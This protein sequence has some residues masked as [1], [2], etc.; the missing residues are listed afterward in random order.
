MQNK[1]LLRLSLLLLA[2]VALLS[3]SACDNGGTAD[4]G[5]ETESETETEAATVNDCK[6][7]GFKWTTAVAATCTEKGMIQKVCRACETVLDTAETPTVAHKE[8]V[9][10][11]TAASCTATGLSDGKKC[12]SCDAVLVEQTVI[13]KKAHTE[14]V[15]PG[16]FATCTATGLTQGKK[17]TLCKTVTVAQTEIPALSHVEGDW[18]V[19]AAAGVGTAGSKHTECILCGTTMKTETIPAIDASHTH[20]GASWSV[21]TPATCE[22]EGLESHLCSCGAVLKTRAIAKAAHTEEILPARAA[23]CMAKGLT[24]GKKCSVCGEILKAQKDVAMTDH[25]PLTVLGHAA[26]CEAEGLSDGTVCK[27]CTTPLSSQLVIPPMGHDFSSGVCKNCGIPTPPSIWIVDGLGNP[28]SDVYVKIFKGEERVKT[29]AFDGEFLVLKDLDE[30]ETY[31]LELDLSSLGEDFVYDE[32]SAV[33]TPE[34]QS[35]TIR[36]YR[37]PTKN[38]TLFVGGT[39]N[40]DY[41]VYTLNDVGAYKLTL[42]PGDC[43]YLIFTPPAAAIYT[44]TYVADTDLSIEYR[45]ASHYVWDHD[46]APESEEFSVYENGIATNVYTSDLGGNRVFAIK[47]ETATECVLNI[48]NAGDPGTRL[49]DEPWTPYL[50]D[51]ETVAEQLAAKPT[52]TYTAFNL[53]DTTISAHYNEADGYYHLGSV[54]GPVIYIDLTSDTRYISSVQTIC[55]NQRM[56]VYVYDDFGGLLEKR[57]FN[58]LFQQYGMPGDDTPVD[59]PIRVPLTARLADAIR[60]YGNKVGWWNPDSSQNLF[61]LGLP[62]AIYNQDFAWL[63]FCG[64]FQ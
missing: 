7:E 52:G 10:K 35:A 1:Y 44:L 17:C 47:S 46:M 30:N 43:T 21:T 57:S 11:G 49:V 28:V 51:E 9:I 63:L 22:A 26:T 42:T 59:D 36:L 14:T 8:V 5:S 53:S 4:T 25:T 32:K 15:L 12:E 60:D 6:H 13:E 37:Q 41:D 45:G 23:T 16:R 2:L 18:I 50:E 20:A 29:V 40:K 55:A 48:R 3:L 64:V 19:D 62:G 38:E 39:V 24:E 56:G 34:A 27:I 31:T 61:T 54:N 58:E 33:I